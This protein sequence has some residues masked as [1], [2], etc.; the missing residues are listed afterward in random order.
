MIISLEI[1]DAQ[2]DRIIDAFCAKYE[3]D[4]RKEDGESKAHFTKR[5]LYTT[6]KNTVISHEV[7]QATKVARDITIEKGQEEINLE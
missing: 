6:I 5:M 4:I 3:Y 7:E 1:P 2:K